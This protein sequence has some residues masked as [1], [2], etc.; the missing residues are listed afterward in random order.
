VISRRRFLTS[1]AIGLAP[2]GAAAHAQE[3]KAQQAGK[4]WRVGFL[5]GGALPPDGAPPMPLRRALQE[6]GYVEQRN[7]VYLGRWADAKQDRLPGLAVELVGLKVDVIVTVGGPASGAAKQA[8]SSIPI[9]MAQVG[10]ADGLGLIDSLARPGGNVT[11]VTDQSA[12]L[13]AKRLEILKEAI[14]KAARIAVLWNAD[15]RG[16]T[17]RYRNVEKAAQALH[18]TVQPLGVR[19]P[20]DFD[21]AF[22]A[23]TQS[24]P[25]ALFLVTDALT[26]LNRKRVIDFAL[27]HR[28]PAMYEFSF[29]VQDG[30]LMSYGAS[31][32]DNYRRAA[33]YV[34][35]LF[36]GASASTLPVERPGRYYLVIN[37]KTAKTLGLTIPPSVLQR[38]D[39]VIE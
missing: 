12:E 31:Q 38:A 28:I 35:R 32:D 21:T 18:V 6:L 29:L 34:D 23:M 19:E 27:V 16:M 11:G 25:D 20:D 10:D 7:V 26:L 3:Y 24:R 5:S 9:V 36:K 33:S 22:S 8:T 13:S 30:G 4:V 1:V 15:D 17:L 39:Q 2:I 37:L 14:P